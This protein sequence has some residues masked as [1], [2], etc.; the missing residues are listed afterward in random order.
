MSLE[1]KRKKSH[2]TKWSK[3]YPR[4]RI[5][6]KGGDRKAAIAAGWYKFNWNDDHF[7]FFNSKLVIKFLK[8]NVGR[9]IDKVFSEFLDKCDSKLRKSYPL[10]E[11]FYHHIE[12]KEDIDW[13]GGFYVTNGILNYKKRVKYN[14][15]KHSL[16]NSHLTTL[17]E[18]SD[19]N[20]DNMP[21]DKDIVLICEKA[22]KTK[23]P[24]YLGNLYVYDKITPVKKAVYIIDKDAN[25]PL[26][27]I[28]EVVGFGKGIATYNIKSQSTFDRTEVSFTNRGIWD[29]ILRYKLVTK[30]KRET[31]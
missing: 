5:N 1:F 23:S 2:S 27:E 30:I 7:N 16:I 25:M 3:K 17:K 6:N 4:A 22:N 9:P 29:E 13:H 31:L 18:A 12:K 10:K 19:Y 15:A 28:S 20:I 14:Y 11:E 26:F 8:A 21:K 24:Q